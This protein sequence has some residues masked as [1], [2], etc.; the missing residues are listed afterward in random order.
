LGAQERLDISF[1]LLGKK[2]LP[3][4]EAVARIRPSFRRSL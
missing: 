3:V 1:G 2:R 4:R